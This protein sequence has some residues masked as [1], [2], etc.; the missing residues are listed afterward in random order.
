VKIGAGMQVLVIPA[1]L[2]GIVGVVQHQQTR[3]AITGSISLSRCSDGMVLGKSTC[4]PGASVNKASARLLP[5]KTQ[6]RC[7]YWLS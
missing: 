4:N 3:P 7:W 6:A 5:V 1:D 2:I